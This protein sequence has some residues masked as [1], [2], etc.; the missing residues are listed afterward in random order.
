MNGGCIHECKA[1]PG[2]V[3]FFLR[4]VLISREKP[5]I[6]QASPPLLPLDVVRILAPV[7]CSA[8]LIGSRQF[9]TIM[10]NEMHGSI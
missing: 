4:S 5:D 9:E 3:G 6:D 2:A 10:Q 8:M 1:E 7:M